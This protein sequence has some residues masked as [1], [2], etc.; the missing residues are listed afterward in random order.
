MLYLFPVCAPRSRDL[1]ARLTDGLRAAKP[2]YEA[3]AKRCFSPFPRVS[4]IPC[5]PGNPPPIFNFTVSRAEAAKCREKS[6]SRG[7]KTSRARGRKSE[8]DKGGEK[9]RGATSPGG[10]EK[11]V[12]V[13]ALTR[14]ANARRPENFVIQPMLLAAGKFLMTRELHENVSR[15]RTSLSLARLLAKHAPAY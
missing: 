15:E 6:T 1:F 3:A 11:G 14:R 4:S 5:T 13:C 7:L 2:I 12:Q 9:E 8:K 10:P